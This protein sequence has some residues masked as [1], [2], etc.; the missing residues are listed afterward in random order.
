[1]W[2]VEWDEGPWKKDEF[3]DVI[4]DAIRYSCQTLKAKDAAL[5]LAQEKAPG[6]YFGVTRMV[7]VRPTSE[8]EIR[9]MLSADD[10]D[11]DFDYYKEDGQ[12]Y[13]IVGDWLEVSPVEVA[14]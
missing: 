1:M 11:G 10:C 12:L 6:S 4:I 8:R 7:E 5:R 9:S 13:A 14:P 3:G 2:H